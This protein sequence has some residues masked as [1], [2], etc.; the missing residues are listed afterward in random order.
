MN[1]KLERMVQIIVLLV[2]IVA[3]LLWGVR[4]LEP[5]LAFYPLAGED[6]TPA[7]FGVPFTALTIE[8][9]DGE[10]LRAWHLPQADAKAQVVYFHGNG[11]NLAMWSEILVALTREGLDVTAVDYRGYGMSTGSPSEQGLYRD[12][13]ATVDYVHRRLRRAE[14]PIVYWGR[15]IGT[16]VAA[17]AAA[18][19]A[20]SGVVLEAGFPT[21]RSILIG[22]PVMLLLS[23]FA[24]Y[25]FAT[26]EWMSAVTAPALVI[27][28]DRDSVIPYRLGRQ[29]YEAL[30]GPKRFVTIAGGNHNDATPADA[31]AY[32][33]AVRDFINSLRAGQT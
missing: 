18:H 31:A 23:F 30:P 2:V 14:V 15:S 5:R 3:V 33:T 25:R 8:T 24:T 21:A 10:A 13:E 20:P 11:G 26:S 16:A 29:L 4:R 27:H 9:A 1:R 22:N 17:R 6:S 32:W 28:G 12:A 7:Q 19:R